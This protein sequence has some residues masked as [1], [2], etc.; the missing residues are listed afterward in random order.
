M[1]Y[2]SV[3]VR[4]ACFTP[5]SGPEC[6]GRLQ[7]QRPGVP[8]LQGADKGRLRSILPFG[9]RERH[10]SQAPGSGRC[11]PYPCGIQEASPEQTLVSRY[12]EC[13]RCLWGV[14]ALREEQG[15]EEAPLPSGDP[16]S[17]VLHL[18]LKISQADVGQALSDACPLPTPPPY[19]KGGV[20]TLA[21]TLLDHSCP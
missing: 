21:L 10:L 5:T 13:A 7:R 1:N 19:L 17:G 2:F 12:Q 16:W 14:P 9:P 20:P 4:R 11:L 8:S 18:K 6:A 3:Q 15:K